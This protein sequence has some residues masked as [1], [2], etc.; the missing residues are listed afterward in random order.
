MISLL[1][2]A[3]QV[4][5]PVTNG[6][7]LLSAF[8]G[9]TPGQI[10][11]ALAG[12]QTNSI[13][14]TRVLLNVFM[15]S[16]LVGLL[17]RTA[18]ETRSLDT[19]GAALGRV[20]LWLVFP[21]IVAN[22]VLGELPNIG[23][24]FTAIGGYL[25]GQ[26][27]GQN[28]T[29]LGIL[30]QGATIALQLMITSAVVG[31]KVPL[32]AFGPA[33]LLAG[34]AF[35]V[36]FGVV[37]AFTVMAVCFVRHIWMLFLLAS[38]GAWEVALLGADITRAAGLAYIFRLVGQGMSVI[39]LLI[40]LSIVHTTAGQWPKYIFDSTPVDFLWRVFVVL[41]S[42]IFVAILAWWV[43]GDIGKTVAAAAGRVAGIA[44]N[45]L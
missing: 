4:P 38:V 16:S 17:V 40:I 13:T 6:L 42:S 21:L 36:A 30:L 9:A 2:Q 25:T 29:P 31:V 44:A 15:L 37:V 26:P 20:F 1:A 27:A 28:V 43:S 12:V 45:L 34:I 33:E 41:G 11:Q 39:T 35:L 22:A 10:P 5:A 18:L 3:V 7:G 19:Y 32:F 23:G 14:L 24:F 8:T